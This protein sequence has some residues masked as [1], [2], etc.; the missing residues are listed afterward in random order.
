MALTIQDNWGNKGYI[1]DGVIYINGKPAV[2]GS[3][4]TNFYT[5]S[6][7]FYAEH[8]NGLKYRYRLTKLV[9]AGTN[10]WD[11]VGNAIAM[12][13]LKAVNPITKN[14]VVTSA[15]A[16]GT[17]GSGIWIEAGAGTKPKTETFSVTTYLIIGG[18]VALGFLSGAFK[19]MFKKRR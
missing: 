16:N 11:I 12:Q 2:K 6:G 17:S 1:S 10:Y 5:E 15:K 9:P 4:W 8:K 19:A 13:P 18:V 3:D 7:R 14:P